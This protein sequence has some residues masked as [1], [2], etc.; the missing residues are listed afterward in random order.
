MLNTANKLKL[1]FTKAKN[2]HSPTELTET[3]LEDLREF[4]K[5][6]LLI[7]VFS[8]KGL[9]ERHWEEISNLVGFKVDPHKKESLSR[10]IGMNLEDKYQ[11]LDEISDAATKEFSIEKILDKVN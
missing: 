6:Q 2:M 7:R 5:H 1:M 10:F 8:N 4:Q 3:V 11:K 9:K